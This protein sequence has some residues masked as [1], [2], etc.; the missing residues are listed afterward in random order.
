MA[1][2]DTHR[3]S[4]IQA[5]DDSGK[6]LALLAALL[7]WMF[8]GFEIGMFPLVGHNSLK[9][10]LGDSIAARPGLETEWFGVIMSAFLIGAA[11]GGVVFGW[12]GDRI[13][14]VRSMALSIGTYAVFT[15][16]CAFANHA[17]QIAI[18]RFIAS[19]GM[20]GEWALGVSLVTEL[21]PDRSRAFLAG[22]IGAAANVGM[23]LVGLLS[24]V[25]VSF[26]AAAHQTLLSVGVSQSMVDTLLHNEGW[27]LLMLGGALPALMTV[28]II[29]FV[30]ESRK[31]ESERDKGSTSHFVTSDLWGVLIGGCAAAFVVAIWSPVFVQLLQWLTIATADE[32]TMPAN[33]NFARWCGT[34]V[35]VIVSLLGFIYPVSRYLSRAET[36]HTIEPGDR[37]KYIGRMLLGACLAGVALLG[38]WG[39]LQWAPK[40]ASALAEA[41]PASG[42]PYYAKEYT[43][44]ASA[45]G[46][47]VG[48]ILAALVGGW[49]GRRVTYALLCVGSFVSLVYMYQGNH[50]FD[51]KLLASVF[52]A[53][54]LTAAFYGWFP[55]YLPELFPTS[56][57]ATS[58][59]FAYNFGRVLSAC[60]SVHTARL[61]AYFATGIAQD[62]IELDAFPKAG[63]TLAAIY[64]VGVFIVWLGPETKG[65]PLPQ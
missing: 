17:W 36:A 45:A 48:T 3:R 18:L 65:K 10:L 15:G 42:G 63:A 58:Q 47:V 19:L 20:G 55:L 2:T 64:L 43:Q 14:R 8:D 52:V 46:A 22:L 57:R 29:Y 49:I 54:G 51:A 24:L 41:L 34:A 50:A 32:L 62:R 44:I 59:G 39:S 28:F 12:F 53:G 16:L 35:G 33:I 61:T 21:W 9:D 1:A 26:L 11:T 23:L 4:S 30:P 37:K 60:G 56:I 27:R 31:W 7:G 25:L 6:Y 5:R 40:W 38:T 13:G